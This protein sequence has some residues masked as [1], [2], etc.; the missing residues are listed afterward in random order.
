[1][2]AKNTLRFYQV[3]Q[4]QKSIS[5]VLTF[6]LVLNAVLFSVTVLPLFEF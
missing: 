2:N 1:L 3:F 4:Q 6:V 5:Q